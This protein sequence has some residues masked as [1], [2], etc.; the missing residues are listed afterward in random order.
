[1][2]LNTAFGE[3]LKKVVLKQ[4]WSLDR[5]S[6]TW[7]HDNVVLNI[8]FGEGLKKVV[9]KQVWFLDRGSFTWE[10]DFGE[11]LKKKTWS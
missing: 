4:V 1:M 10:H 3:G 6:F 7:E 2:V 8:A 11:G 5:G 9:L